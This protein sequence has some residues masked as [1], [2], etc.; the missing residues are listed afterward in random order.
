MCAISTKRNDQKHCYTLHRTC[1]Q[2]SSPEI[3][4][5]S[6]RRYSERKPGSHERRRLA[7]SSL[8]VI[9]D[10]LRCGF[11]RFSL[12]AHLRRCLDSN[13]HDLDGRETLRTSTY[14]D[15]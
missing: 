2:H 3:G 9:D 7:L 10:R 1:F 15:T 12:C 6:S 14:I 5:Q 11:A 4:T 13:C 8:A